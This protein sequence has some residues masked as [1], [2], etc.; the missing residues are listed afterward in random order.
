MVYS[1]FAILTIAHSGRVASPVRRCSTH[2]NSL[3]ASCPVHMNMNIPNAYLPS[4]PTIPSSKSRG[5]LYPVQTSQEH[6]A[7]HQHET[8]PT[9]RDI[10]PI[11]VVARSTHPSIHLSLPLRIN[12]PYR[13]PTRTE[14]VNRKDEDKE[15]SAPI[16]RHQP[17]A[18]PS[19]HMHLPSQPLVSSATRAAHQ[20]DE[21]DKLGWLSRG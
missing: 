16:P 18:F 13:I 11:P 1:R 9:T 2:P 7:I 8:Q 17:S 20:R 21:T 3:P 19:S 14:Q 5:Y 15:P 6:Q 10:P 4:L 12:S